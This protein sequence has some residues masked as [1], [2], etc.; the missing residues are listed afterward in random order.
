LH[1]ISVFDRVQKRA[2]LTSLPYL[3]FW[4]WLTANG[5]RKG[6]RDVLGLSVWTLTETLVPMY[7]H[8]FVRVHIGNKRWNLR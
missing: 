1:V 2:I 5:D 6:E 8:E 7:R 4:T 3:E